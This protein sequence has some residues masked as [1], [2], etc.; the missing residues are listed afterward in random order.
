MAGI[1]QLMVEL[2]INAAAFTEG[3]DKATYKSKQAAK[4]IGEAFKGIG[5]DVGGLIGQFGEMGGVLG[6]T[7]TQAG[8]TIAKLAGQMGS[9]GGAAGAAAIGISAIGA[10]GIAAGAGLAAM[11]KEGAEVVHELSMV[12]QKTGISIKDL[13]GL[14]AAGSTV[15][16]SLDSMVMGF[17]KFD[18]AITGTGRSTGAAGVILKNLGVT[19]TNNTDA[20]NQ[21]ADAFQKMDDGPRKA[22]DAIALFG[23][24]G[25]NLIPLL[26][27]GR[28]GIAEFNRMV[29]E[30]GPK[31]GSEA[32]KADEDFL[33]A[34]AKVGLAW[35]SMKVDIE[36]KVLPALTSFITM[37]AGAM[38]G[39]HGL[40]DEIT[41]H[42]GESIKSFVSGSWNAIKENGWMNLSPLHL[43]GAAIGGGIGGV[44]AA[45]D[46]HGPSAQD[47]QADQMAAAKKK[48]TDLA[49]K[50]MA[51]EKLIALAIKD[52]G[53]AET[54]L[55]L[56]KE[57]IAE[58]EQAGNYKE[59][60][61]EY[62]KLAGLEKAAALEKEVNAYRTNPKETVIGSDKVEEM[63]QKLREQVAA[64]Q[65][66]ADTKARGNAAAR[67]QIEIANQQ[68]SLD[69]ESIKLQQE[70]TRAR[71]GLKPGQETQNTHDIGMRMAAVEEEKQTL[72]ANVPLIIS[73]Y[74][75]LDDIKINKKVAEEID[76]LNA[77]AQAWEANA[78]AVG[79]GTQARIVA[80]VAAA[81]V[82]AQAKPGAT[83]AEVDLAGNAAA[84]QGGQKAA[85]VLQAKA[86]QMDLN[87]ALAQ[88]LDDLHAIE[89]VVGSGST[90]FLL[91]KE[92]E[93][94]ATIQFQQEWIK[95]AQSVGTFEEGIAATF[96]QIVI[97]GQDFWQKFEQS[98]VTALGGVEDAI[99]KFTVTGKANFKQVGQQFEESFVKN[100]LQAL[101]SK[102]LSTVLSNTGLGSLI[103]GMGQAK[104]D[105]SSQGNA[106]WVEMAQSLADGAVGAGGTSGIA[107]VLAGGSLPTLGGINPLSFLSLIPGL[108]GGGDV[109][110]GKAYVVGEDHPEFFVPN[111]PGTIHPSL[112]MGGQTQHV[113]NISIN[114][115]TDHDS[116]KRNKAQVAA[117]ISQAVGRGSSRVG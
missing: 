37:M 102:G 16:L 104:R 31:I 69:E 117:Q 116:F 33:V 91:A 19:A 10:V 18:Q 29:D 84:Q 73:S 47:I 6:E 63:V 7:L 55:R 70:M 78:S 21:V 115:V 98:G 17:R 22:A 60:G 76:M 66:L 8:E 39:A 68:R 86:A 34:Q 67:A 109:M 99:A 96:Q 27:K 30:Y 5:R 59:A 80:E 28:D 95:A 52:G 49:E 100:G 64:E 83:A 12:S 4:E 113:T 2:G 114:G 54:A 48:A 24:A 77:D 62:P 93:K 1:G 14:Q 35:D 26:N 71:T 110:P 88:E 61:K 81:R 79:M 101:A 42:L 46:S 51:A 75:Q 105:G 53:T 85:A 111:T 65:M 43:A 20:L 56:E 3:I 38:K 94:Q 103:P 112:K 23:R 13:Q 40:G 50:Q 74:Q 58:L 41:G 97:E 36:S 89:G 108:A 32:V 44:M 15:G 82:R 90:A 57:K 11:A 92:K 106:L 25:L 87:N 72:A 107:S 45:A 9:I